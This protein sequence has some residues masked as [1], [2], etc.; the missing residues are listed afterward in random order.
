MRYSRGD[1]RQN[2]TDKTTLFDVCSCFGSV[3]ALK[4][5]LF[6]G[7]VL[8][9]QTLCF[10]VPQDTTRQRNLKVQTCNMGPS[11]ANRKNKNTAVKV[12]I[13]SWQTTKILTWSYYLTSSCSWK[14]QN[15]LLLSL[16]CKKKHKFMSLNQVSHFCTTRLWK[17][18]WNNWM[19]QSSS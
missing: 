6:K 14:K 5:S 18:A 17:S 13:V 16:V 11:Q 8:K 3:W 10:V 4:L 2:L 1:T 15:S 12:F 19:H 9:I 7:H